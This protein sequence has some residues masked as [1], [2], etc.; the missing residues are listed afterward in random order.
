MDKSRGFRIAL[1]QLAGN[2][3]K[4]K[5]IEN[6]LSQIR[7]VVSKHQA[8]LVVLPECFNSPYGTQYFKDF[9]EEIPSGETS[10]ALSNIARELKIYLVCGSLPEKSVGRFYN[11]CPVFGPDGALLCVHRKV[12]LFDMDIPGKCTFK[13]S[14]VLTPGKSLTMFKVRNWKIGLG[15]CY[16]MRFEEFAKLYRLQRCDMLIYPGA[17]DT[18]TGP[19]HWDLLARSRANDNQVFVA[20]VCGARDETADYV[21][22]AHTTLVDP[23]GKVMGSL[24]TK[25]DMIVCDIDFK[26]MDEVRAQIPI[27]HQRRTDLYDLQFKG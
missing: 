5:N 20:A 19:M 24:G 2:K 14:E 8:E 12:H 13:E 26:V 27:F 15:I 17:F 23:W 3:D 9:A 22:Y 10:L 7:I 18:F 4:R 25:Q 11:S 21:A 1:L 16:D 6:A